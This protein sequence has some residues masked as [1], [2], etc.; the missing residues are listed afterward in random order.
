[1]NNIGLYLLEM[2]IK[3]LTDG[4]LVEL[5]KKLVGNMMDEDITNEEKHAN[6]LKELKE[7]GAEFSTTLLDVVI[8]VVLMILRGK[9]AEQ[10]D[11]TTATS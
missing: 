1:M 6:V 5:A 10:T 9:M 2:G 11:G 7:F 8:K 4:T 3:F